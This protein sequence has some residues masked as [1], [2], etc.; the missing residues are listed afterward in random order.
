MASPNSTFTEL[1]TTTHREH[2][3]ELADNVSDHNAFYRRLKAKNKIEKLDGGRTIVRP[4][5]YAENSTYQRFSGYDQLNIGASDVFTAAEYS[6]VQAAVHITA[7]GEELRKNSGRNQIIRLAA[8]RVRNA[9][10]TAANMMSVD[11]YSSGALTNQMGGLAHIITT[12]G[13]GTV[14]GIDSGTYTFWANQFVEAGTP[15]K[16]ETPANMRTMW[17]RCVRGTDSPDLILSTHDLFGY[18]WN[19]LTDLQRY[20][21][22]KVGDTAMHGFT[23]LKFMSADVVFDSNSNF[24]TTGE[25]MY[26]LN[27][28]YLTLSVHEQ[29]NWTQ[30]DDKVSSNQDA[31][32]IPVLWMGNLTCSNRSLQGVIFD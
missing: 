23:A 16:T 2:P 24:A 22:P 21:D 26:F 17:L 27:T 25:K 32:I 6:W 13:T 8:S 3:G 20:N 5:E 31:V 14:G 11:L 29:A 19:S 7:S 12:A 30:M 1:V 4:L 15:D 18:F 10:K 9:Q 28:D